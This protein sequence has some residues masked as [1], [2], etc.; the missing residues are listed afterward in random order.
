MDEEQER[1]R[2][3]KW[4]AESHECFLTFADA[5]EVDRATVEADPARILPYLDAFAESLPFDELEEDDWIWLTTSTA[6]FLSEAIL[7][8]GRA[9]WDVI[10]ASSGR[11][12]PV[13]RVQGYD[14]QEHTV[15]PFEYATNELRNRPPVF[16][17]ALAG[18]R[19]QAGLAPNIDD[20]DA[21]WIPEMRRMD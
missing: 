14:G 1:Q 19:I 17:R 11:G 9:R 20:D 4:A 18:M 8:S 16:T 15:A 2:L 5:L 6:A 21:A 7:E 13:L 3:E 10:E 12:V